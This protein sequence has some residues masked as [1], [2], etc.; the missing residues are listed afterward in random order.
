[1]ATNDFQAFAIG[2]GANVE[3]QANYL[4]DPALSL[5]QQPG[6]AASALNNKAL[7]QATV[8]A[9]QIA[10]YISNATGNNV[11]DDGNLTTLQATMVQAF[12]SIPALVTQSSTYNIKSTDAWVICSGASWVP[13]LPTASG[14]TGQTHRIQ[15]GGTSLSQVY[16]ITPQTGQSIGGLA[17]NATFTLYTNGEVLTLV[18]DG[19]NW[20]ILNHTCNTGWTAAGA[21]TVGG[22]TTN[23]TKGTIVTDTFFWKR[24]GSDIDVLYC[25]K[26]SGAG[27]AG[28]GDYLYSL[29][30]GLVFDTTRCPVYTTVIGNG[31]SPFPLASTLGAGLANGA[32]PYSVWA[33]VYSTT[34]FRLCFTGNSEGMIGSATNASLGQGTLAWTLNG[35][36]P[37]SGWQP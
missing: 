3:T 33:S 36:F 19:S 32:A 8:I 4:L 14:V 22:T 12:Q 34:Q 24:N 31:A 13:T 30:T 35:K 1:M 18:S 28:S 26:Q 17:A 15:H 29:P 37:M 11:L 9:S 5:G 21:I 7:R 6:L 10:Q 27:S 23:P 16:A 20:Q 25:L 2:G